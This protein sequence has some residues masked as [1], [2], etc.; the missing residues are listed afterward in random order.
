MYLM[1][2]NISETK[3][4]INSNVIDYIL[5]LNIN[6]MIIY[7]LVKERI[8]G[9]FLHSETETFKMKFVFVILHV[10]LFKSLECSLIPSNC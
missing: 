9:F 5:V 8:G 1:L 2:L 4:G 7:V 3:L 10:M 6:T